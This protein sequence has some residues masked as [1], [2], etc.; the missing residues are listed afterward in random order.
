MNMKGKTVSLQIVQNVYV[1]FLQ[2]LPSVLL[3]S[4]SSC[5]H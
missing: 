1:K 5:A 2:L 3:P 4:V